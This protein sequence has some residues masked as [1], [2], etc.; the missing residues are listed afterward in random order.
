MRKGQLHYTELLTAALVFLQMQGFLARNEASPLLDTLSD[1]KK[2]AIN[3]DYTYFNLGSTI[4]EQY[5]FGAGELSELI[6][7]DNVGTCPDGIIRISCSWRRA[8]GVWCLDKTATQPV[9]IRI[10]TNSLPNHCYYSSTDPPLGDTVSYNLVGFEVNFNMEAKKMS[11]ALSLKQGKQFYNTEI[12]DYNTMDLFYCNSLWAR[13]STL[14]KALQYEDGISTIGADPP[15]AFLNWE[16]SQDWPLMNLPNSNSIVGVAMNGVFFFT[17]ASE[18]KLDPFYPKQNGLKLKEQK[19]NVDSCMGTATSY[20]TYM[21]QIFTPC[22]F[23]M[24]ID[25]RVSQ[26]SQIKNCSDNATNYIVS[27]TDI[28]LKTIAPIG[29]A[30]DGRVIYGPYRWDGNLWQPCDVDAAGVQEIKVLTSNQVVLT[31][32]ESVLRA[33]IQLISNKAQ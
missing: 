11:K 32:L 2:L 16:L 15:P 28:G 5:P 10:L 21:Y 33:A 4:K 9:R 8:F 6:T 24:N 25:R 7:C 22:M 29:I 30:R 3:F 23:K 27:N 31:I 13:Q 1:C 12:M 14:D 20:S 19:T 18:F 17:S 26:C